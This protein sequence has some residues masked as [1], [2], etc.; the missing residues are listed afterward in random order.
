MLVAAVGAASTIVIVGGGG[1][2]S[3]PVA[4]P[5]PAAPTA[6][7][8]TLTA[9]QKVGDAWTTAVERT[10]FGGLGSTD[11]SLVSVVDA[12]GGGT[13]S[14]GDVVSTVTRILQNYG[15]VRSRLDKRPPIPGYEV[16]LTD[17]KAAAVLY[18]ESAKLARV[19]AES[20]GGQYQ[21]QLRLSFI[22]V[23]N[24]ADRMFFAA[25]VDLGP[26]CA[27]DVC[28]TTDGS[29]FLPAA[30]VPRW[31]SLGYA[32]GPPLAAAAAKT[33]PISYQL[34]RPEQPLDKWIAD[35]AAQRLPTGA[36]EA[37]A[38]TAGDTKTLGDYADRLVVAANAL[39]DRPDPAGDRGA[40]RRVRLSMLISSEAAR[41]AESVG[42]TDDPTVKQTLS[43]SAKVLALV[44][45]SLWDDRLGPRSTGFPAADLTAG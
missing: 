45:D 25:E 2:G 7:V 20:T 18:L 22:R 24:L 42:Y 4:S 15:D 27:S 17:Y 41:A 19:A 23:H 11:K 35:V 14:A 31:S 33:P 32:A 9:D 29:E 30:D 5:S 39:T 43:D 34:T 38:I 28:T 1:N 44:G 16:A 3:A 12:W 21:R 6:P 36:E 8:K 40:G 13:G 37:A 10:D 26:Y